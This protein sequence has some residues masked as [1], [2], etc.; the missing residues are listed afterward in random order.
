ML[1]LEV[2]PGSGKCDICYSWFAV[3]PE[4]GTTGQQQ[5]ATLATERSDTGRYNF[6][7]RMVKSFLRRAVTLLT[8]SS[9]RA[10]K[11]DTFS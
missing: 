11:E 4:P 10:G 8:F 3:T 2:R 6:S 5:L 9:A 7:L 1:A